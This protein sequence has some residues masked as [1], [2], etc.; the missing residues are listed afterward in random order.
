MCF[1][2]LKELTTYASP[3]VK[4][5]KSGGTYNRKSP[6]VKGNLV[7]VVGEQLI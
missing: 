3:I 2:E 1:G 4:S 6:P 5:Y 7:R